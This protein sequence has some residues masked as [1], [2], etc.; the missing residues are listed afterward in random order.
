[1]PGVDSKRL[2]IALEI[3]E[4]IK[5]TLHALENTLKE[6]S[7]DARWVNT[8]NIHLTLKFLGAVETK[9]I[10]PLTEA[11]KSALEAFSVIPAAL[12]KLDGFPSL[13]SARVLIAKVNNPNKELEKM[14]AKLENVL[15]PFGLEKETRRFRAHL[16]LARLR[17]ERNK[18]KLI[19]KVKEANQT[20]QPQKFIINSVKLFE[21]RLTTH[22][23]IYT[24]LEQIN[25]KS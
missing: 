21:S 16:T 18:L 24:S 13:N 23:P 12:D 25:L 15:A 19:E 1:M 20:L 10:A 6:S 14:A 3:P 8:N 22:G 5:K 17:S 7:C 4:R 9:K 2:F 11:I